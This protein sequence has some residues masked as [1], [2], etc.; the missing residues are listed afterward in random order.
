[1]NETVTNAINNIGDVTT[2]ESFTNAN[3]SFDTSTANISADNC[4]GITYYTWP[5]TWWYPQ[6]HTHNFFVAHKKETAK[7]VKLF[8]MCTT[9]GESR[10][11]EIQ[12]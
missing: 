8:V 3:I 7:K 2:C 1:M 4:T 9:C 10:K 6:G 5:C 12:I 11:I